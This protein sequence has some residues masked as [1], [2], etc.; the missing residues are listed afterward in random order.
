MTYLTVPIPA[1]NLRSAETQI[2]KAIKEGAQ[3]LEL[4]TDYLENL[5]VLLVHK[6][7]EHTKGIC[8]KPV[9]IIVTC[10]DKKEGG[11][12]DYPDSLR[13]DILVSAIK[14]NADFV[15]CEFQ[16]F[17]ITKIQEKIRRALSQ[18]HRSKLILSVHNFET[19]FDNAE[20]LYRDIKSL[21]P[22]AIAKIVYTASDINDCFDALD[23]LHKTSGEK[24]VIC[25]GQAGLITR[26]LAK[27]L[28]SLVT[29]VSID[30]KSATAPGQ[31]SIHELK[32]L[33]RYDSI[34]T[35]TQL[36]GVI[37]FPIGHSLS[38]AIFNACFEE[39][40]MN[41]LYLP[42]LL[43]GS[44]AEFNKFLNKTV[45]RRWLNFKGFSVTIPHK[46]NAVNFVKAKN[47]SI[48]PLAQKIAAAN[49]LVIA[50]NEKIIAYNTDCDGSLKAI[51][52]KLRISRRAFK[53]MSVAVVGAGG[54][55]RAIVAGL[56][57]AGAKVKIYNRTIE[58][59][60]RLAT[61]F[62]CSFGPLDKLTNIE[63][64][65]L[66]NC[67]SIGMY[68]RIKESIVPKSALKKG[69]AV[70]DTVYNPPKT[71]LLKNAKAAGAKTI[72]GVS[73]FV[74]QAMAQ[75]KLFTG[76]KANSKIMQKT[77]SD[78]LNLE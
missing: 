55:A 25:L 75:F 3:M 45:H 10:R 13:T 71:L 6:L 5:S 24:I 68:P 21:Y 54:V 60:E 47:G 36:Y 20:K 67:T 33:Y 7:I 4:R 17:K 8:K 22:A 62:N 72:D 56:T 78:C 41:A 31:L 53:N 38:P 48:E 42:L 64:K 2:K 18:C 66:V 58:K 15:D 77:I 19:K 46:Q 73:M 12:F 23:L 28:G 65:L 43:E 51:T 9:P 69:M 29:F 61:E 30:E 49:T 37:G 52:S 16:N 39:Q 27:K 34:D 57:D 35:D 40:N 76:K 74:N 26:I 11:F 63:T 50:A 44:E 1:N 59:A 70:F 32:Q 14:A